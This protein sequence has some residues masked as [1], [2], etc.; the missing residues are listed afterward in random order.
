MS[1]GLIVLAQQGFNGAVIGMDNKIEMSEERFKEAKFHLTEHRKYVTHAQ[2]SKVEY[3]TQ[4]KGIQEFVF[5]PTCSPCYFVGY[6]GNEPKTCGNRKEF[7]KIG[8]YEGTKHSDPYPLRFIEKTLVE[9]EESVISVP[10]ECPACLKAYNYVYN[11]R[12]NAREK[13]KKEF[14]I[15]KS[16][17]QLLQ[18]E[19]KSLKENQEIIKKEFEKLNSQVQVVQQENNNTRETVKI[20]LE[21]LNS[22]IQLLQQENKNMKETTNIE[23]E[24]LRSDVLFLQQENKNLKEA[25]EKNNFNFNFP[26]ISENSNNQSMTE[27]LQELRKSLSSLIQ[28]LNKQNK[29]N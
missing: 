28:Q 19:N 11:Y 18:Q 25:Q 20:E 8:L 1:V 29:N 23:F 21:K 14:E 15:F 4:Q 9:D 17:V 7:K 3:Q 13:E 16:S 12:K 27:N 26:P 22:G 24:K 5:I 2:A 10:E 6:D